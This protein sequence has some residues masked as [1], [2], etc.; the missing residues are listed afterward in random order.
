MSEQD[1]PAGNRTPAPDLPEIND[2]LLGRLLR[3]L[4]S[5]VHRQGWDSRLARLHVY[6]IYDNRV[7]ATDQEFRHTM[8]QNPKL[9]PGKRM[10]PLTAQMMLAPEVISMAGKPHDAFRMMAMNIAYGNGREPEQMRSMIKKPGVWAMAVCAEGYRRWYS[11]PGELLQ[12]ADKDYADLPGSTEGRSLIC[13]D[14][15]GGV[16]RVARARGE[17]P[18]LQVFGDD[19]RGD[20][21]TSLR[22]IL[23]ALYSRVPAP[24]CFEDRYPTIEQHI[25][26]Q[27]KAASGE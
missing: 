18:E 6:L 19:F 16:H 1:I 4:E 15:R 20:A 17:K 25:E 22:I 13:V 10:G 8:G 5:G 9:G 21:S 7:A 26:R 2:E 14:A 12:D 23:D 3:H 24:D 11:T 27:Q